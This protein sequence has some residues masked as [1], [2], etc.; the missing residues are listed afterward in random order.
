VEKRTLSIESRTTTGVVSEAVSS[1][2]DKLKT[3][4]NGYP[5][6]SVCEVVSAIADKSKPLPDKNCI[7]F[8][9]VVSDFTTNKNLKMGDRVCHFQQP[10]TNYSRI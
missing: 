10:A 6:K 4:L 2:A 8:V 3:A 1:V 7:E 9:S 5:I